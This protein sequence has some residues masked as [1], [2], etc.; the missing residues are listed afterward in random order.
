[1]LRAAVVL[2]SIVPS[3]AAPGVSSPEDVEAEDSSSEDVGAKDSSSG[4]VEAEDSSSKGVEAPPQ[5]VLTSLFQVVPALHLS[6]FP[7]GRYAQPLFLK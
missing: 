3:D 7:C 6:G 4:D 2:S 5:I 1:M